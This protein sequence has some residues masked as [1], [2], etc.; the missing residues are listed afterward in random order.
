M[1]EYP[2][3]EVFGCAKSKPGGYYVLH[4]PGTP[5]GSFL[6]WYSTAP[7]HRVEHRGEIADVP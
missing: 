3:R 5:G 1:F 7:Q 2:S 4:L 6:P